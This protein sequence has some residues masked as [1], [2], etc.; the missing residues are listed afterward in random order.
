MSFLALGS[1][2]HLVA[3]FRSPSMAVCLAFMIDMLERQTRE[4]MTLNPVAAV[5]HSGLLIG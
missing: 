5:F 1:A 4:K 2:L 3:I